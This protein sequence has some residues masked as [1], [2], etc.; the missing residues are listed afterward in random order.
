MKQSVVFP[1][2]KGTLD[3]VAASVGFAD[4]DAFRRAFIFSGTLP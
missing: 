3:T 2:S 4:A 1:V